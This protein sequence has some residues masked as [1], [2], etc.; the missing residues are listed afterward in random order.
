MNVVA[1]VLYPEAWRETV[2]ER[3]ERESKQWPRL[4]H[5]HVLPVLEAGRE[6]KSGLYYTIRPASDG[7]DL[8]QVLGD[9]GALDPVAAVRIG[10]QAAH[11]LKR[12]I[13]SDCCTE[14]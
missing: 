8:E 14:A 9:R 11:A 13:V 4:H 5:P 2:A 7:R 3:F 10:L 1:K 6:E 12:L